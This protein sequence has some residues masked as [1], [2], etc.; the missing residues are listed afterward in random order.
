MISSF[1]F[2]FFFVETR[3]W[4]L[5]ELLR[6]RAPGYLVYIFA[7]DVHVNL[8][9]TIWPTLFKHRVFPAWDLCGGG[10][11]AHT[12]DGR[13][14]SVVSSS[15]CATCHDGIP[16]WYFVTATIDG[17]NRDVVRLASSRSIVKE[18]PQL[19]LPVRVW[20]VRVVFC[21]VPCSWRS[22]AYPSRLRVVFSQ[23]PSWW[24]GRE[25]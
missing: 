9:Y 19:P 1:S 4:K 5:R 14:G 2:L 25:G 13:M 16:A 11:C 3:L 23:E 7:A 21:T 17:R 8:I 12:F 10:S 6:S 22:R 15:C 18:L 24:P 20:A